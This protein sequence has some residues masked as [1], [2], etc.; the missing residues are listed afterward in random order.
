M[1]LELVPLEIFTDIF[2]YEHYVRLFSVSK[3]FRSKVGNHIITGKDKNYMIISAR[4]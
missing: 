2:D 4:I 1:A 3:S